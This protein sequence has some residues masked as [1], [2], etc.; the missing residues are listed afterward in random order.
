MLKKPI[1]KMIFEGMRGKNEKVSFLAFKTK[2]TRKN[3][4]SSK[5]FLGKL[6]SDKTL[7]KKIYQ[8]ISE[9]WLLVFLAF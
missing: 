5:F 1:E 7:L 4:C 6:D 9:I 3:F 2:I 8:N